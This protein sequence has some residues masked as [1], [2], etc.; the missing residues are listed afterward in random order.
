MVV[1]VLI[2]YR[3]TLYSRLENR[4]KKK[5]LRAIREQARPL[6]ERKVIISYTFIRDN[7]LLELKSIYSAFQKMLILFSRT[8]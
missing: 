7:K 8:C 1:F 6:Q 3:A 4:R 5:E 2:E